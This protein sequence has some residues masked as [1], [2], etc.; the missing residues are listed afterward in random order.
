MPFRH[1]L[2][3]IFFGTSLRFNCK[4]FPIKGQKK[5]EIEKEFLEREAPQSW[6]YLYNLLTLTEL[7]GEINF[8]V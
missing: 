6:I 4:N 1:K 8:D 5:P 7:K 2:E 3:T